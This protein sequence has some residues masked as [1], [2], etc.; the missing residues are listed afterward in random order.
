[1]IRTKTTARTT[2][3]GLRAAGKSDSAAPEEAPRT[4]PHPRCGWIILAAMLAGAA[5]QAN[6]I[7]LQAYTGVVGGSN[8]CPGGGPP[9]AASFFS[10]SPTFGLGAGGNGISSCGLA[11]SINNVINPGILPANSQTNLNN[12]GYVGGGSTTYSGAAAANANF[13]AISAGASGVLTGAEPANGV[14]ESIA[15]GIVDDQIDIAGSGAGYVTFQFTL[16]GGLS[17][18]ANDLASGAVEAEVQLGS[19]SDRAFYGEISE[20]SAGV[21]ST[22]GA[23]IPGCVTGTDNFQ[24][25]NAL[26]STAMLPIEFGTVTAFDLGLMVST[27]LL[28]GASSV[29]PSPGMS[30]TGIEVFNAAGTQISDFSITSGSGAVYGASGLVSEPVSA[31]PEPSLPWLVAIALSLM[32]VVA[33]LRRRAASSPE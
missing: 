29:D 27:D 13:G 6:P 12:A 3:A 21:F 10:T 33:R 22:T 2:P 23:S 18:S 4:R 9:A 20:N 16:N 24:C 15:F 7:Q 8:E 30:L 5:A 11:G 1:M 31:T 25:T 19:A 26:V 14:A 17:Q 32:C 28:N